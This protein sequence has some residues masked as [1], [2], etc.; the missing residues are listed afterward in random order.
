MLT[1]GHSIVTFQDG[2]AIPDRLTRGKHGQYVEYARRMLAAYW[3]GVGRERRELHKAVETVLAAE[4]DCPRRRIAAFC[5]L[6]DEAGEFDADRAGEAAEL[7]L[8]VFALAAA[9][10]PLLARRE[11]PPATPATP[12]APLGGDGVADRPVGTPEWDVK[13]RIAR[14][15]RLPWGEI[16]RALYADVFS[17]QR[18]ASFRGYPSADA[19]L[20]R[21]NVGQ[22]QA[23]LYRATRLT[24]E[25]AADFKTILRYAKLARLLHEIRRL[26]PGRYHLELS[27]PASVLHETRRYGVN[28]ARFVPALL[29][30][31]DWSLSAT[32]SAPWGGTARLELCSADGLHSH[33]PPPRAFDSGVELAFAG[34]FGPEREGWRLSRETEILHDGQATFLPDFVFRRSDGAKGATEVHLEIVGFWTPEYLAKKRQTLSRFRRRNLLI[35]LPCRSLRPGAAAGP[36]V[37]LYKTALKVEPVLQALRRFEWREPQ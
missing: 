30:C 34:R 23:C 37:I 6:L 1:S 7:R 29:A 36:D 24:V 16:D 17:R 10:H 22:V 19:L 33:L 35:A 26:G 5:K 18:L 13:R 28:F 27:G 3:G 12:A 2:R 14:E 8:R 31:R 11:M 4:P 15:L 20:A 21:Y 32:L 9:S 25:A